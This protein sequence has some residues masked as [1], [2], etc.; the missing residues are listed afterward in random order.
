MLADDPY[1]SFEQFPA[2]LDFPSDRIHDLSSSALFAAAAR[3]ATISS[4]QIPLDW[5]I[6]IALEIWTGLAPLRLPPFSFRRNQNHDPRARPG[7]QHPV[8]RS[9][10]ASTSTETSVRPTTSNV[11]ALSGIV[12]NGQASGQVPRRQGSQRRHSG[13]QVVVRKVLTG[14]SQS[15]G[16]LK[17]R[18]SAF[19]SVSALSP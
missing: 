15:S 8:R 7:E 12:A 2:S 5:S 1:G 16:G 6:T 13:Q 9:G 19:F 18:S 10:A 14:F 11:T 3:H 17:F 4:S